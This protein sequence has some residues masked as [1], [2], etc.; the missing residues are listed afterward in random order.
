MFMRMTDLNY[1]TVGALLAASAVLSAAPAGAPLQNVPACLEGCAASV[2]PSTPQSSSY[3]T[4]SCGLT[5][6]DFDFGLTVTVA[7]MSTTGCARQSGVCT[8]TCSFVVNVTA[9]RSQQC[10]CVGN[11]YFTGSECGTSIPLTHI[12]P[13]NCSGPCINPNSCTVYQTTINRPC[14][15]PPNCIIGYS[16]TDT[17]SGVP[18]T[19]IAGGASLKCENCP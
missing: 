16:L 13:P 4:A 8:G 18:E 19:I 1:R 17:S 3:T 14:M 9:S 15:S 10:A 12:W 2:T 7:S 6:L 11:F 5:P